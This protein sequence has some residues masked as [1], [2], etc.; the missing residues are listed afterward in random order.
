MEIGQTRF[1]GILNGIVV[2]VSEL[3]TL[4][5]TRL[6]QEV[7]KVNACDFISGLNRNVGGERSRLYRVFLLDFPYLVSTCGYLGDSVVAVGVSDGSQ[8]ALI[9]D[10]ICWVAVDEDLPIWQSDFSGIL[11]FVLVNV[12]EFLTADGARL[13]EVAE[14]VVLG[15][16][17]AG[18]GYCQRRSS[19][20]LGLYPARLLYFADV[21]GGEWQ[22]GELVLTGDIGDGA[23]FGWVFD[24]VVVGIQVD[25][26]PS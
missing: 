3:Q 19:G 2:G 26:P 1:S 15:V 4:D 14:V 6:G 20:R 16:E 11:D 25:C 24:A 18:E 5:R 7:A 21:V 12:T 23:G 17:S 10:S 22:V 13:K 8:F 9:E